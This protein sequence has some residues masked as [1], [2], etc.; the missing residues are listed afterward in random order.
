[1]RLLLSL[2]ALLSFV[3]S[4]EVY[5]RP[6][7]EQCFF[8]DVQKGQKLLVSMNVASGGMLD[9]D[10]RMFGPDDQIIYEADRTNEDSFQYI[11]QVSGRHRVCFVNGMSTVSAKTVSFA[12]HVGSEKLITKEGL[13][14]EH[15]T[16]LNQALNRL[17][18]SAYFIRDKLG[19]LKARERKC[20]ASE[21]IFLS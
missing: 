14:E 8:E 10:L 11:A 19:F 7:D 5:I 17:S 1:M 12:Y 6:N 21:C 9:V 20:A 15:L 18:D 3:A 4:F 16:P 13:K 2:F